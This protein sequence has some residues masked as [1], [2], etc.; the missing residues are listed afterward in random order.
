MK[1]LIFGISGQDGHYLDSILKAQGI[2]CIGVS[3]QS[4]PIK[5]NVAIYSQV[6]QLISNHQPSYIFHLA[7]NS[8]TRHEALFENHE[9]ISTG[10]LNI[11][12]ATKKYCPNAK[13]FITG[14]GVQFQ[15]R[16]EPISETDIFESSSPYAFSRIHSVYA[17][18]YYRSLGMKVYVGYLFHHE[19]P[20]RKNSHVSQMIALTAQNIANGA[21]EILELGDVSVEKEWTFAGDIARA[22]FTLI[23]QD[24]IF[25]ATIGSGITYTI[26]NWLELCFGSINRNWRNYVKIR[27]NFVPQYNRLVSNPRTINSMGWM[28]KVTFS[29][30][31]AMMMNS[32]PSKAQ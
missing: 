20:L 27:Q 32:A 3:R 9:T 5:A 1:A 29:Q 19:S 18:R 11:L 16:G 24:E 30:L 21:T 12:E 7:A 25:E 31:S 6:E 13:V 8:T 2:Q 15:N 17:A 4:Y 23:Q 14:S 10:T 22:I 26:E 28:P